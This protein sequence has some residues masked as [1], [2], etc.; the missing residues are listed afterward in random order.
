MSKRDMKISNGIAK[1]ADVFLAR[2]SILS[3]HILLELGSSGGYYGGHV[4]D[5]YNE[6]LNKRVGS[7]FGAYKIR[8]MLEFF[9]V[10]HLSDIK[11]KPVRIAHRGIGSHFVKL[12][13]FMD[14]E[15]EFQW[16]PTEEDK[17]AFPEICK[18]DER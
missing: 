3:A 11:D 6:G 9:G 13:D 1:R 7:A 8:Q 2:G 10:D 12:I 16:A 14:D 5:E 4:L 18:A 17:K 15:K